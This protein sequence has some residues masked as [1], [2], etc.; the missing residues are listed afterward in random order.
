M[1][2]V[3]FY[4]LENQVADGPNKFVSHLC[5]KLV[6]L[7]NKA[8]LVTDT[9]DQSQHLDQLL[10]SFSDT[11]FVAH[12]RLP[13]SEA[14]QSI[15]HIIEAP[16]FSASL[17]EDNYHVMV[18]LCQS[19]PIFSHHFERIVEVIDA[20][21]PSKETARQRYRHYQ[22]EGFTLKTHKIEL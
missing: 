2:Q 8:L 3:D 12:D 13:N 18:N 6:K 11:S 7:E 21:E 20:D 5:N 15:I 16:Q 4:L 19:V 9:A 22:N 14:L 10:W 17:T 1:K